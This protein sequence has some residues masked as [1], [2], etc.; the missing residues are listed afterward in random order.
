MVV[1]A[2]Y[3]CHHIS[4]QW[5]LDGMATTWAMASLEPLHDQGLEL[6][7]SHLRVDPL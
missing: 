7:Y 3:T 1:I 4:S 6:H 5:L 2:E